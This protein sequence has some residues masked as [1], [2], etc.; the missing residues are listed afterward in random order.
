MLFSCFLCTGTMPIV[1]F[2][3]LCNMHCKINFDVSYF[4]NGMQVQ[5]LTYSRRHPKLHHCVSFLTKYISANLLLL[6]VFIPPAQ[7]SLRGGILVSPCPPV[8]PYVCGQNHVRCVSFIILTGSIAYLHIL[9]SNFRSSGVYT[10]APT[11]TKCDVWE[12]QALLH[13]TQE[14]LKRRNTLGCLD[15]YAAQNSNKYARP[16]IP[17]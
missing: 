17:S 14:W 15:Q 11:I 5:S 1:R 4:Q 16:P 10:F 7:R 2:S 12:G 6:C 9:S 8:R 3:C 13:V